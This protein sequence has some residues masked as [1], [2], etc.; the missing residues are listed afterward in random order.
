MTTLAPSILRMVDNRAASLSDGAFARLVA[1]NQSAVCAVAYSTLRDRAASE[2]VAQE[3]FLIA[4]RKLPELSEPPKMPAWI[5]GIARNLAKN[6]RRQAARTETSDDLAAVPADDGGPLDDLLNAENEALVSRA[7]AR[8]SDTYREPLVLFY[9]QD[10]SIREVAAALDISE[11]TAKQRLSR[12]REQ[13]TESVRTMVERALGKTGPG[14]AFTAAVVAAAASL[15]KSAHA[16]PVAKSGPV[17]TMT[18]LGGLLAV[19]SVVGGAWL[20]SSSSPS[21]DIGSGVP[22]ASAVVLAGLPSAST[23]SRSKSTTPGPHF[24]PRARR[25]AAALPLQQADDD[26]VRPQVTHALSRRI[27]LELNEASPRDVLRL[28]S[29]ISNTP[30]VVKGAIGSDVTYALHAVTVQQ[31]LDETL[32]QAGAVWS[33]VDVIKVYGGRSPAGPRLEGPNVDMVLDAADFAAVATTLGEALEMPVSIADALNPPPVTIE[34]KARPA[35]V[36]FAEIV[37]DEGLR[38]EVVPGI[39]VAPDEAE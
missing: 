30:I 34:A 14:A 19:G 38:Y 15:P 3:A 25:R 28:L 37:E 10:H 11:A 6:A 4:W 9:R 32:E 5:C 18:L 39:E 35:G 1:E 33:D 27:D 22:S 24:R 2:E 12:G 8:L 16:A 26:A 20:V 13:L 29:E 23:D 31:A 7:L 36:L 21:S 17:G